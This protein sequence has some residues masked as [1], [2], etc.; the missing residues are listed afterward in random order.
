MVQYICNICNREFRNSY[1]YSRHQK[2]KTPCK[3][4]KIDT[5]SD[6]PPISLQNLSEDGNSDNSD[7]DIKTIKDTQFTEKIGGKTKFACEYCNKTFTRKDNLTRHTYDRCKAKQKSDTQTKSKVIVPTDSFNTVQNNTNPSNTTLNGASSS[8]E[9]LHAQ[10]LQKILKELEDVKHENKQLKEKVNRVAPDGATAVINTINNNTTNN[11]TNN[12]INQ[13]INNTNNNT[14]NTANIQQ[15]NYN[16]KILAFKKEDISHIKNT[17]YPK[18]LNKGF[19][20]IEELVKHI[21]FDKDKPENHNLYITNI[22]DEYIYVYD[23]EN[24][25][26]QYKDDVLQD[27]I[28]RKSDIL[29]NKHNEIADKLDDDTTRKFNRFLE[30]K[31]NPQVVNKI[32]GEL[33]LLLYNNRKIPEHTRKQIE[34]ANENKHLII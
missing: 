29:E 18:I 34:L 16:I 15:N 4:I 20:S 1:D 33:K 11:I 30:E 21:H 25:V 5:S 28:D 14:T 3:K 12:T 19:K 2:R 26:V 9:Q 6:L 24:W 23:G 27:L 17:K 32:K 10:I 31:D 8:A 13:T 22:R 7:N